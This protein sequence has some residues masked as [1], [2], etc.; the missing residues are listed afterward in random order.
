MT[1]PE[2][3]CSLLLFID[4]QEGLIEASRTQPPN[5]I[6]RA[7]KTL[8]TITAALEIPCKASVVPAGSAGPPPLITEFDLRKPTVSVHHRRTVS[9]YGEIEG[10]IEHLILC[11]IACEAAILHTALDARR[12]GHSVE[13]LIDAC[14]GLSPRTEDAAIRQME[15]SGVLISSI[16]SFASR[17]SGDMRTPADILV[18]LTLQRMLASQSD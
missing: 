15:R 10:P 9:A 2:L 11:G 5:A 8:L 4:L 7:V 1:A 13:V 6:R 17:L 14:G 12:S 3:R 16:A 18:M